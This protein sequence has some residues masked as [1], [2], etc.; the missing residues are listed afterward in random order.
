MEIDNAKKV[1]ECLQRSGTPT[2]YEGQRDL[3]KLAYSDELYRG[4]P[5]SKMSRGQVYAISLGIGKTAENVLE[6][7]QQ[8]CQRSLDEQKATED[9][10][11]MIAREELLQLAISSGI[12][13]DEIPYRE[14][15]GAH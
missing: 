3:L 6:R 10:E 14:L 8:E 15:E 9:L 2:S 7:Y 5:I 11:K 1:L 12:P 4:K 13:V